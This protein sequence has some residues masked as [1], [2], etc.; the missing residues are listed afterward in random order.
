M[1]SILKE[2]SQ[3]DNRV[4]AIT[5]SGFVSQNGAASSKPTYADQPAVGE[6]NLTLAKTFTLDARPITLRT[7]GSSGLYLINLY[8]SSTK[9]PNYRSGYEFDFIITPPLKGGGSPGNFVAIS[10]FRNK[11]DA[12]NNTNPLLQYTNINYIPT[13]ANTNT[14]TVDQTTQV[15]TFKVFNNS[16]LCKKIPPGYIIFS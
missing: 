8:L 16:L 13:G 9:P 3:Q 2:Y 11:S 5:L 1:S 12:Y 7:S 15:F 14:P 6:L 4:V 10:I